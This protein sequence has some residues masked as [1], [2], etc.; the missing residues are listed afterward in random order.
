[1]L[2][3]GAV[4]RSFLKAGGKALQKECRSYISQYGNVPVGSIVFTKPGAIPNCQGII[5][6]VGTEY[7]GKHSEGV[8]FNICNYDTCV[9]K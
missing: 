2:S 5:H 1:V 6:T 9:M 4:S 8:S 7:D 3:N